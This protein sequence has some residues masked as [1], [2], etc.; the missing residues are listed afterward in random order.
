MGWTVAR[1]RYDAAAFEDRLLL[2][3]RVAAMTRDLFDHFLATGG[4]E[5]K[6]IVFCAML[7]LVLPSPL[8]SSSLAMSWPMLASMRVIMA[9]YFF[10]LSVQLLYVAP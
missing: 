10:C 8:G 3:E 5:Q 1:A 6:T 9:A 7:S 4:P 2:S